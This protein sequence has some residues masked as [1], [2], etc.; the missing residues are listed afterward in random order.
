MTKLHHVVAHTAL[1]SSLLLGGC[2]GGE[3][4]FRASH[5]PLFD[6]G[7]YLAVLPASLAPD[8]VHACAAAGVAPSL[9]D[10]L[11]DAITRRE[12][13]FAPRADSGWYDYQLHALEFLLV[14]ASGLE[15]SHLLLTAAYKKK[16]VNSFKSLITQ[17][18]ETHLKQ[19][20]GGATASMATEPVDLYPPLEAE[21]LP[22]FY[23]RLGRAYRFLD[24]FLGATF[25]NAFMSGVGRLRE[26]GSTSTLSLRDELRA[27]TELLYGLFAVTSG[28]LGV[29]AATELLPDETAELDLTACAERAR[30]WLRAWR[31]DEDVARDPRMLVPMARLDDG[32]TIDWAVIGVRVI[33]VRAE[34]PE[35]YAPDVVATSA[36]QV[37]EIVSHDFAYLVEE[38]AEVRRPPGRAPLTR[39]EL[40]ALC[41]RYR[42]RDAIVAA[43]EE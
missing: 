33:A 12:V 4:D 23:L 8:S 26:D 7:S 10:G 21:P 40:R 25:G 22:T 38:M 30:S 31:V 6:C 42:T 16:L 9:I 24:A 5:P 2:L 27:K 32:T 28:V 36:C 34:W 18:R 41:D 39:S 17:T 35:G 13:S 3:H 37:G 20:P 11:I 43:L 19:L 15:A 1:A 29:D 14:P